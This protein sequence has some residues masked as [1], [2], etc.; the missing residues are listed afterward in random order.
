MRHRHMDVSLRDTLQVN[1]FAFVL[2]AKAMLFLVSKAFT[3]TH[4]YSSFALPLDFPGRCHYILDISQDCQ[5]FQMASISKAY[6]E[7]SLSSCHCSI[8]HTAIACDVYSNPCACWII[9]QNL[10]FQSNTLLMA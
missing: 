3:H 5:C 1:I 7:I 2:T 9:S 8:A 10:H 6:S 4:F